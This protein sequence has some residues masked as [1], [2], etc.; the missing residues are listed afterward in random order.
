M[1]KTQNKQK[2]KPKA[3]DYDKRKAGIVLYA[4]S[5]ARSK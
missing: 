2:T 3:D 4:S 1:R 5:V